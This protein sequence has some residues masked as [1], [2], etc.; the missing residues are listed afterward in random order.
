MHT[1]GSSQTSV[2]D[3]RH[4]A[5]YLITTAF[6]GHLSG[7]IAT[8]IM[9]ASLIPEHSRLILVLSPHNHTT[10][11]LLKRC[12]FVVHLLERQQ[13]KV[14][15]DFGLRS[16]ATTDKFLNIDYSLTAEGLPVIA[17]TCG[18]ARVQLV[19]ALDDQDRIIVVGHVL[20]EHRGSSEEILTLSHLKENLP[21]EVQA[22]LNAKF[23]RDQERDRGLITL[24]T[25]P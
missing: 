19:S 3:G 12:M 5:I 24:G 13:V 17:A 23:I 22:S 14:V 4:E 25:A 6:D 21:L 1:P 20:E 11:L 9:S 8:W 7:M 10:Q 18:W 2:F 16:S 15:P